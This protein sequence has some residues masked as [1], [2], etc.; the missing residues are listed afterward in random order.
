MKTKIIKHGEHE[1]LRYVDLDLNI[2]PTIYSKE[3]RWVRN[4]CVEGGGYYRKYKIRLNKPE[5]IIHFRGV[6]KNEFE[7]NSLYLADNNILF[8]AIAKNILLNLHERGMSEF[9]I[10]KYVVC[11]GSTFVPGTGSPL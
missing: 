10:P 8:I 2:I 4:K 7:I 3:I 9:S 11:V 6:F 1:I 5:L